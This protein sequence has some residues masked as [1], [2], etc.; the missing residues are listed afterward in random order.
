MGILGIV[1]NRRILIY[2]EQHDNKFIKY[3]LISKTTCLQ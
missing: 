2:L 3:L 1:K